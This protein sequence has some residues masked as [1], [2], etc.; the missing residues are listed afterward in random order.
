VV[1]PLPLLF[2]VRE[3]LTNLVSQVDVIEVLQCKGE[4]GGLEV[5]H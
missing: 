2:R 4:G 3:P 1:T 5:L